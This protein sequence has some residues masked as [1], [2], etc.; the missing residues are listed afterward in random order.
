MDIEIKNFNRILAN[1]IWKYTKR[2]SIQNQGGFFTEMQDCFSIKKK[3]N[4]IIYHSN[5]LKKEKRRR[6]YFNR[7]RKSI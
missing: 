5:S 4:L 1:P 6:D 2:A 3:S 7:F